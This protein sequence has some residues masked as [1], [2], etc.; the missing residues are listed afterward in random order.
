M[1]HKSSLALF[2]YWNRRRE[3]RAAPLR[4][5]IEPAD[6]QTTLPNVFILE[7]A[8]ERSFT[9]RLA[10]T[11]ICAM[12]GRELRDR[13]LESLWLPGQANSALKQVG[14]AKDRGLP[15]VMHLSG[16]SQ[17]GRSVE[18]E[19]LLLPL[20]SGGSRIDRFLGTANPFEKPYWLNLDPVVGVNTISLRLIDPDKES[21]FL[22]NR[23]E[24]AVPP[25]TSV[26]RSKGFGRGV[27]RLR[28]LTVIEGGRD[29]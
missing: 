5:E 1:K 2:G 22:G 27:E 15:I 17:A 20:V 8:A 12:F 4:R 16:E 23:P 9:F 10:G 21:V 3:E 25:A 24:I 28:R 26:Y 6:I 11:A 14:Y 18:L 29:K 7:W 13:P 19:L